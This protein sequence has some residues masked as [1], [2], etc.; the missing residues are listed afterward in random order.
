[1]WVGAVGTRRIVLSAFSSQG[2]LRVQTPALMRGLVYSV[3]MAKLGLWLVF[4]GLV[5]APLEVGFGLIVMA[6]GMAMLATSLLISVL[7]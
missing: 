3:A 6:L 1:M 5:I 4:V 7:R 2:P